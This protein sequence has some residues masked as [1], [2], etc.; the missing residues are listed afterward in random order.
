MFC[1]N[2]LTLLHIVPIGSV[3]VLAQGKDQ[4]IMVLLVDDGTDVETTVLSGLVG[5]KMTEFSA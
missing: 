1:V 2:I 4:C 3:V 5:L